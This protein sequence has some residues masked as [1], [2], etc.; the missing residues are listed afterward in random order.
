MKN[1]V[2]FFTIFS[3]KQIAQILFFWFFARMKLIEI[4]LSKDTLSIEQMMAKIN[5]LNRI[6]RC[7]AVLYSFFFIQFTTFNFALFVYWIHNK[8]N[9]K[10]KLLY[11]VAGVINVIVYSTFSFFKIYLVTYFWKLGSRFMTILSATE[12]INITRNKIVLTAAAIYF[13]LMYLSFIFFWAMHTVYLFQ[14][15]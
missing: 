3:G 15:L 10:Y 4:E 11:E 14:D 5:K 7:S 1:K 9:Y 13:I 12:K 8:D 2:K 6:I